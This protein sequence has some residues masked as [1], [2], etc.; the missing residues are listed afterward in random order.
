M[1]FLT[2]LLKSNNMRSNLYGSLPI[3]LEYTESRSLFNFTQVCQMPK[4]PCCDKGGQQNLLKSFMIL[5]VVLSFQSIGLGM[6][7]YRFS[8]DVI[9]WFFMAIIFLCI[10]LIVACLYTVINKLFRFNVSYTYTLLFGVLISFVVFIEYFLFYMR[11]IHISS[12]FIYLT[13]GTFIVGHFIIKKIKRNEH[14][15]SNKKNFAF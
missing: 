11:I 2:N 14:E 7:T 4:K 1:R 15:I 8:F 12:L 6:I 9:P 5:F 10:N 3:G 13:Y